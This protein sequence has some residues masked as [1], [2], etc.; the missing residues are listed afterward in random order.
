MNENRDQYVKRM[1]QGS[2]SYFGDV[3]WLMD[4]DQGHELAAQLFMTIKERCLYKRL[5]QTDYEPFADGREIQQAIDPEW[6]SFAFYW[7]N[8]EHIRAALKRL[9]DSGLIIKRMRAKPPYGYGD[10]EQYWLTDIAAVL[11]QEGKTNASIREGAR[12]II[13]DASAPISQ[14]YK[15]PRNKIDTE[16][17]AL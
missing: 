6:K 1:L 5:S 4:R 16:D 7:L 14:F 11:I 12:N 17:T 15:Q 8:R 10:D 9:Q 2:T 3:R 13:K